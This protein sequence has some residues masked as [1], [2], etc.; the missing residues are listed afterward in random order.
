LRLDVSPP[1]SRD[2]W[3]RALLV[4]LTIIAGLYL[5]QM[6]W[7]IFAHVGDLLLLFTIAWIV[8]FALEPTV[9]G[10]ARLPWVS[11]TTAVIGVYLLVFLALTSAVIILLPAV[12]EQ[13]ALAAEQLPRIVGHVSGLGSGLANFLA[14]HNIQI[15]NYANEILRP[16]EAALVA[17][18]LALATGAASIV[19][20]ILLIVVLSVYFML[21][22]EHLGNMLLSAVPSQY[23]DD[24]LYFTGSLQRSFGGFLRGQII[25]ALFYGLGIAIIMAAAGLPF[26]ALSSVIAGLAMF[27]PFFGPVL[28]VIPPLLVVLTTDIGKWWIVLLPS[29]ALNMV[30]V[31]IVAPKVMSQQIGLHPTIVLASVLVGARIA[32][33]WGAVFGAPIVAVIANMMSFYRLTLA[34]RRVRMAAASGGP[35]SDEPVVDETG[36]NTEPAEP[37]GTDA[38]APHPVRADR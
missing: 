18:G 9:A 34:E 26:V 25:Q 24:F 35:T 21:D 19:A 4:L 33:P 31:N 20:Q 28:G 27:I 12:A 2:P 15:A 11:R 23:R 14:S 3:F 7:G 1:S 8:S 16:I 5:G 6:I 38:V 30:V 32:G 17:N 10:L 29:I 37:A 22:G 36:D 13:S